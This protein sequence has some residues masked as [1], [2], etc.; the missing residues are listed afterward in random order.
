MAVL[1]DGIKP[2]GAK[3]RHIPETHIILRLGQGSNATTLTLT[4]YDDL[5]DY[6]QP[7]ARGALLKTALFCSGVIE[8]DPDTDLK[9]QLSNR[10]GGGL[11]IQSWSN[12]PHGSGL[13]TSSI[14]A[15]TV[16]AALWTAVGKVYQIRDLTHTVLILEQMLTTGGGWQDQVGGLGGS[17]HLGSSN[18]SLPLLIEQKPLDVSPE[19]VEALEEAVCPG[20]HWEDTTGKGLI[21]ECSEKMVRKVARNCTHSG[22]FGKQCSRFCSGCGKGRHGNSW[23]VSGYLPET[24]AEHGPWE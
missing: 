3:V 1:M 20:V 8:R 11:E 4:S 9:T 23:E 19:T 18:P 22:W 14:L 13:G 15:G 24:K 2:I 17:L 6:N 12:L 10:Y 7:Q 21:T 5:A 16:L